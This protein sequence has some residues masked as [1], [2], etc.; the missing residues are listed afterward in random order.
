[1]GGSHVTS[2]RGDLLA[3]EGEVLGDGLVDLLLDLSRLI[4]DLELLVDEDHG[5][6][7]EDDDE[8]ADEELEDEVVDESGLGV[9]K[10]VVPKADQRVELIVDANIRPFSEAGAEGGGHD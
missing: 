4:L 6:V 5:D 3:S 9:R 10:V 2:L 7:D 8:A 1:L